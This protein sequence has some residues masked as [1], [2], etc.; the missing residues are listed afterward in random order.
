MS[1]VDYIIRDREAFTLILI[2]STSILH[3]I[4]RH[5]FSSF[6]STPFLCTSTSHFSLPPHPYSYSYSH[7]C[8]SSHSSSY[9]YYYSCSFSYPYSFS[10]FS[11]SSSSSSS[12]VYDAVSEVVG[13]IDAPV[14][15]SMWMSD[16][17][18]TV[19]YL[20]K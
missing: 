9:S 16:K 20:I 8:S 12:P 15:A 6:N 3:S 4:H 1:D 11:S 7:S 17:L 19:R 2:I 10:S 5:F 14:R 18:Y 13:R